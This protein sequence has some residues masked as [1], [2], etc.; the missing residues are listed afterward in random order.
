M[1]FFLFCYAG[2]Q[3]NRILELEFMIC[4]VGNTAAADTRYRNSDQ[5][6]LR[7]PGYGEGEHQPVAPG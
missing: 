2:A 5:G 4:A 7:L 6:W 3:E 1:A